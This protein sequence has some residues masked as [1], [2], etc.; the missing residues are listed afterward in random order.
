MAAVGSFV[1]PSNWFGLFVCT[2]ILG[3]I[4]AC[5]LLFSRGRFRQTLWNV[6]YIVG[7]MTRFRAPYLTREE[8]DVNSAKAITLPHAVTIALG[9]AAF[10]ISSRYWG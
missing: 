4:A 7:E 5:I 3:G 1:G 10:L 8:L 2:A 9:T 6:G